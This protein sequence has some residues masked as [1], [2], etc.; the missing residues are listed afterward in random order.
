MKYSSLLAKPALKHSLEKK[1]KS[2]QAVNSCANSALLGSEFNLTASRPAEPGPGQ[3]VL[4][5]TDDLSFPWHRGD[6]P[7][8]ERHSWARHSPGWRHGQ[9]PST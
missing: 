4:P 8:N 1:K 9:Q 6:G 2:H 3:P 5:A 7:A